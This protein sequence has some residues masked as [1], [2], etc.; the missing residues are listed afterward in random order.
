MPKQNF[1]EPNYFTVICG[2]YDHLDAFETWEQIAL[3]IQNVGDAQA[4][5]DNACL[6]LIQDRGGNAYAML[7]IEGCPKICV[8]KGGVFDAE[9]YGETITFS[10]EI[11]SCSPSN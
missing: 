9:K 5:A 1:G 2:W 4:A 6:Y 8:P 7:V 10:G 3:V 11:V